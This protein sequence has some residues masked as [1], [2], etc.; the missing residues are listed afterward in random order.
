MLWEKELGSVPPC[1]APLG[2]ELVLSD[3][4][5]LL[6]GDF[7]GRKNEMQHKN[8]SSPLEIP[9]HK[10]QSAQQNVVYSLPGAFG[11]RGLMLQI[12]INSPGSH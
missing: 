5:F 12:E 6:A 4:L 1:A 9:G 7:R 10:S 11:L 2:R 3:I 8:S